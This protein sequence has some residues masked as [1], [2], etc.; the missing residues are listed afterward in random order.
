LQS[1]AAGATTPRSS[2]RGSRPRGGTS[3][4][5]GGLAGRS[6]MN[7]GSSCSSG[8]DECAWCS[9]TSPPCA[10][11]KHGTETGNAWSFQ[12]RPGPPERHSLNPV[13]AQ[14]HWVRPGPKMQRTQDQSK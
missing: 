2:E 8:W 6:W 7:V 13:P 3:C 5:A 10:N 4:R 1:S 11:P 9:G 12:P 14:H